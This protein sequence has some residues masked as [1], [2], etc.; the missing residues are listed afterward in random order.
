MT[1]EEKFREVVRR[2]GLD[3]ATIDPET[4]SPLRGLLMMG[5]LGGIVT[6]VL[7]SGFRAIIQ[8]DDQN[9]LLIGGRVASLLCAC[10]LHPEWA[11]A[12]YDQMVGDEEAREFSHNDANDIVQMMAMS[13]STSEAEY[14]RVVK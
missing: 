1:F 7:P 3:P 12:V 11:R 13:S 9:I 14:L 10:V 4:E 2:K 6:G 5:T 8:A